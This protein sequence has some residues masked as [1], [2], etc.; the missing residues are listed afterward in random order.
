MIRLLA[1]K[2]LG[3][4]TYSKGFVAAERRAGFAIYYPPGISGLVSLDR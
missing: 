4:L 2:P 3:V 1:V